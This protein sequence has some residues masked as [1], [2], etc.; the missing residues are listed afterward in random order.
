M[1][2]QIVGKDYLLSVMKGPIDQI[3]DEKKNCEIDPTK[4]DL[5]GKMDKSAIEETQ[6]KNMKPLVGY[7]QRILDA[8]FESVDR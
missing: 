7:I 1:F 5:T 3:F 6:K 2:F 4:I 8:I